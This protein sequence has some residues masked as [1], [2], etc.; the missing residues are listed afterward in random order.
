MI[1]VFLAR[2]VS[3]K[4]TTRAKYSAGLIFLTNHSSHRMQDLKKEKNVILSVAVTA[5][6]EKGRQFLLSVF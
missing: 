6:K 1:F 3:L 4:A 5:D 2:N